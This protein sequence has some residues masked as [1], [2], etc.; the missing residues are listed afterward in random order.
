M[1][2]SLRSRGDVELSVAS[3][4]LTDRSCAERVRHHGISVE[5]RHGADLGIAIEAQIHPMRMMAYADGLT[6]DQLVFCTA[7]LGVGRVVVTSFDQVGLLVSSSVPHRRQRV[8]VGMTHEADDKVVRAVIE[9]AR[10]DLVGLACGID[11]CGADRV[12]AALGDA[13]AEMAQ[14]RHDHGIVLTRVAMSGGGFRCDVLDEWAELVEETLDD[15]CAT[16]RF[17]RPVVMV[18]A[19]G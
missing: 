12:S 13:L 8:L 4:L 19:A 14:I 5:V 9:A 17:P 16:L 11:S 6:A 10:L 15:A 3:G 2:L 1:T 7:S 18:S